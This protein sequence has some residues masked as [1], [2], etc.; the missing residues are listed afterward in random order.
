MTTESEEEEDMILIHFTTMK[1]ERKILH[2]MHRNLA[3]KKMKNLLDN[4]TLFK[5]HFVLTHDAFSNLGSDLLPFYF[6]FYNQIE[7]LYLEKLMIGLH[8]LRTG[9]TVR[10]LASEF[11]RAVS[12]IVRWK[13][14]F[15]LAV[16]RCYRSTF[17]PDN[18]LLR[19]WLPN[20]CYETCN[21]VGCAGALDGTHIEVQFR[22]ANDNINHRN[23]KG[24]ITFNVLIVVSFDGQ[25]AFLHSGCEGSMHDSNVLA[26]SRFFENY[27]DRC[28][29]GVFLLA[30]SGYP[31]VSRRILTP[32]RGGRYHMPEF[33]DIPEEDLSDN[34]FFN[35]IHSKSRSKVEITI[36]QF[37]RKFGVFKTALNGIPTR[38][39]QIIY[40][41]GF[42]FNL[43][44]NDI[45]EVDDDFLQ[46]ELNV[47]D[48]ERNTLNPWNL[49]RQQ[50][51]SG[52]NWRNNIRETIHN[53][54]R[55]YI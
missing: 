43:S 54:Y 22:D 16:V 13:N 47:E 55:N 48:D 15:L 23:R 8:Y 39:N 52:N 38:M 7:F 26:I 30:D 20:Q 19:N 51:Q 27:L 25:I 53:L 5:E 36:G 28:P 42:I 6:P 14:F 3:I 9:K 2:S 45:W 21:F 29:P 32:Y 24:Y 49:T 17:T 4:E 40:A 34:E 1:K 10:Q 44:F 18:W 50:E 46:D 41:C 35:K 11:G 37:K 33:E 12:M 31:L